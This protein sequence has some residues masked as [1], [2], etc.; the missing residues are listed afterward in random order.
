M[1]IVH[2]GGCIRFYAEGP[3]WHINAQHKTVGLFD[4]SEPPSIDSAGYLIIRFVDENGDTNTLPVIDMDPTPDE[5]LT[6]RGITAGASN[7]GPYMRI[8]FRKDGVG[9]LNLNTDYAL[10]V[11]ATSNLWPSAK[12]WKETP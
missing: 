3:V 7:G 2:S 6:R 11:G 9:A 5:E 4:T 8:L 10:L 1:A 12:H